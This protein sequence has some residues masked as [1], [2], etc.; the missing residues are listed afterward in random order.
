MRICSYLQGLRPEREGMAESGM[1][2]ARSLKVAQDNFL[3]N[4]EGLQYLLCFPEEK[5]GA[6]ILKGA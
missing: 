2:L 4:C 1:A 5:L 3:V 6:H